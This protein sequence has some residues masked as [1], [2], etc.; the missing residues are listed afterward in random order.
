MYVAVAFLLFVCEVVSQPTEVPCD[1]AVV[2]V[3]EFA[4]KD[5]IYLPVPPSEETLFGGAVQVDFDVVI[6]AYSYRGRF[7]E[8]ANGKDS[9]NFMIG[10]LGRDGTMYV[11]ST[12]STQRLRVEYSTPL[13]LGEKIHIRVI[14]VPIDDATANF[15]LYVDGVFVAEAVSE[16]LRYITRSMLLIGTSTFA[17]LP[18][19]PHEPL[20][21]EVTNGVMLMCPEATPAPPT[22]IPTTTPTAVPTSPPTAVPT[23]IP[24]AVPT[25]VPTA[26][27]TAVP[28]SVPTAMSTSLITEVPCDG[29]VVTVV[30]FADKDN[31][32][33]PVPPSE[34]TL[35]GGAVQVDFD[36]VIDEYSSYG[37]F[38]E[39]ANPNNRDSFTIGQFGNDGTIFVASTWSSKWMIIEYSTPLPLGEKFHVRVIS[40][41]IDDEYATYYIYLNGVLVDQG[42]SQGLRHVT[43]SLLLI[44]RSSPT[45]WH[46]PLVGE[47]TDGVMLMCVEATPAPPT[48]VPTDAPPTPAPLTDAP[49][50]SIPQ[51]TAVPT[52]TPTAV[53]TAIPTSPPTAVPTAIPTA[54]P[55]TVPTAGPTA[56]P[57][58]TPTALPTSPPTAIPSASPTSVPTAIPTTVPTLA[59]TATPTTTPTALPTAIP[60][61]A[62][63]VIPTA[64]PTSPPTA[65][66]TAKPTAIPTARPTSSPT[67][68]PT[69]VP[70]AVPTSQPTA[71]PTTPARAPPTPAPPLPTLAPLTSAPQTIPQTPLLLTDAPPTP[72]LR[73]DVPALPTDLPPASL[74]TAGPTSSPTLPTLP[75]SPPTL[76]PP[77]PHAEA[78]QNAATVVTV[79]M[80]LS[81]ASPGPAVRLALIADTCG[82]GVS[83]LLHPTGL[84]VDGSPALGM[85]VANMAITAGAAVLSLVVLA[86]V[87][88]IGRRITPRFFEGLDTQGFLRLPS[89]PLV[90]FQFFYQGIALAGMSLLLQPGTTVHK[91]IGVSSILFC[92]SVPI[93]LFRVVHANVPEHAVLACAANRKSSALVALIGTGEWVNT[94]EDTMWV[95]RYSSVVRSYK[96]DRAWFGVVEFA[97]SFAISA[98][99]SVGPDSRLQCGHVKMAT[100]AIFVVLLLC[101]CFLWP[102]ARHR[103]AAFDCTLIGLQTF[104]MVF[105]ALDHYRGV[106]EDLTGIAS[107]LLLAG[108]AVLGLQVVLD[109]L[110]EGHIFFTKRRAL[111]Q[112]DV[113]AQYAPK[114][115]DLVQDIVSDTPDRQMDA[116][117]VNTERSEYSLGAST[118]HLG[119]SGVHKSTTLYS[120]RYDVPEERRIPRSRGQHIFSM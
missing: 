100:A 63:T 91:L 31:I 43:R 119:V 26:A 28:T 107:L 50:T 90:I 51:I 114:G 109:V 32:Y 96:Q 78:I 45:F 13:P 85:F 117:F 99:H 16:A 116:L 23:A 10:Q 61:A 3:V 40:V 47:V 94:R 71:E 88:P 59:P 101:E 35:F 64:E 27:P 72:A 111:L 7:V 105:I 77:A 30:E 118:Q 46:D 39:F 52:T 29:A 57:T 89:A 19:F 12:W 54:V 15:Y 38:V 87:V 67:A 106:S 36:V 11:S 75:A 37:R 68:V 98:V 58:T 66:P 113:Y 120:D 103:T 62:P 2:T 34:E 33:L 60:T 80:L 56:I 102:H 21:G 44:G 20:V 97:A 92:I 104:A 74:P 73:T 65:V 112:E 9:D 53:P 49:Q 42:P 69:T 41:P 25:T 93:V 115:D 82:E 79:G 22:A 84:V 108:T 70:T 1:G 48:A 5:N 83:D 8:F 6:D 81:G 86:A 4:D 76:A 24:T 55:T 110:A 14:V 17:D 95:Q 18:L